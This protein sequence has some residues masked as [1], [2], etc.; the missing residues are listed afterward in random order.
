[1]VGPFTRL[2]E[3]TEIGAV[4]ELGFRRVGNRLVPIMHAKILLL[5]RMGWTDEHPSGLVVD[6]LYFLSEGLWI[7]S[8]N[9]TKSSRQNLELGC[10]PR[11]RSA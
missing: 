6:I 9:F 10:G 3:G 4:R 5:G 8:A 7:G 1:M 11:T 2:Q